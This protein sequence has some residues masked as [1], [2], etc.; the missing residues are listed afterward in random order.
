MILIFNVIL[1]IIA[2]LITVLFVRYF[3]WRRRLKNVDKK[4]VVVSNQVLVL[5]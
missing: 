3:F 5:T 4:H 1:I 2:L